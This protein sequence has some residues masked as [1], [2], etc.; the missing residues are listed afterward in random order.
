MSSP[1]D[2]VK[3]TNLECTNALGQLIR[4]NDPHLNQTWVY[5]YDRGGNILSKVRYA[6]TTGALGTALETIPYAYGDANWKD[7]LTSYNGTAITY[8]AIGNP[9]NDGS[10][11]YEWSVGRQLKKMSQEGQSLS[12][13]YDHNGMRIRKVL[14]HSWYPETTNYTYHGKLLTHME[15]TY[16]DFDEVEY[17]DKLHFFYDAQS[18]PAKVRF[19]GTTYTYLHN[20]QGDIVGILDNIGNL[21]VEYKYDAWGKPLSTAGSLAD[22]LGIRNPFRYRGYVYDEES[23]LYYLR[24]RFYN[25]AIGQFVN[26]D[27]LL[28]NT[29]CLLSH[30]VFTY[31]KCRPTMRTD[32]GGGKDVI[33]SSYDSFVVENDNFFHNFL[34]NTQYYV[35]ISDGTRYP[36]NSFE[37]VSLTEWTVL[38][39][40]FM[41][42]EFAG[43][44]EDAAPY[45][46]IQS[47]FEESIEGKLDF[48]EKLDGNKLYLMNGI[49]YNQNEAGNF[50]WAYFLKVH[51]YIDLF[52]GILAQGGSIVQKDIN[53]MRFDEPYDRAA[54]YAGL[55]Y[56]YQQRKQGWLFRLKYGTLDRP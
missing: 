2:E 4:V 26:A 35:E 30:N 41:D 23:E 44:I 19:N 42:E 24:S 32:I 40:E 7:K 20:L 55:K 21:V 10:W 36:A 56:W 27:T 38:D 11:T 37:T 3:K 17:T 46:S 12:F 51:G 47:V 16:T 54:R 53:K 45:A 29:R 48:K 22:T 34:Y 31:T 8:D 5:N 33:Y 9:L 28:G 43:H 15:V 6:Y 18:R 14:E 50:M 13:K 39:T 52:Q 25:S 1:V 49:V